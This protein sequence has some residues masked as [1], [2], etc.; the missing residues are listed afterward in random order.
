MVRIEYLRALTLALLTVAAFGVGR[1]AVPK[2]QEGETVYLKRIDRPALVE[3]P[4]FFSDGGEPVLAKPFSGRRCADSY[5]VELPV[6]IVSRWN[7]LGGVS[8]IKREGDYHFCDGEGSRA[9]VITVSADGADEAPV[10]RGDIRLVD[11]TVT[12]SPD[13]RFVTFDTET[14]FPSLAGSPNLPR[15]SFWVEVSSGRNLIHQAYV[16]GPLHL[17]GVPT[18]DAQGARASFSATVGRMID[19]DPHSFEVDSGLPPAEFIFDASSLQIRLA[20]EEQN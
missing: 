16:D 20:S 2:I 6:E 19:S 14:A 9:Q 10:I 11:E 18:W 12:F 5:R 8:L 15:Q 13:G 17:V 7:G 4:G 3:V 1:F